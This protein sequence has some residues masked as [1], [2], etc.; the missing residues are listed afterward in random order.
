MIP[1][2][3]KDHPGVKVEVVFTPWGDAYTE[4]ILTSY[5][6]GTGPDLL[7][8]GKAPSTWE[9]YRNAA[10]K[11]TKRDG[12]NLIRMGSSTTLIYSN[13]TALLWQNGGEITTPDKTKATFN[14]PEGV[15][16]LEFWGKTFNSIA[17]PG[18]VL[19]APIP[20][21]AAG[22]VAMVLDGNQYTARD[23]MTYA[24]EHVDDIAVAPPLKRKEQVTNVFCDWWGIGSQSKNQGLAWE[25]LKFFVSTKNLAAYNETMWFFPP[26]KSAMSAAYIK[27]SPILQA[28]IPVIEKYGR[29]QFPIMEFRRL[30][31][32][33]DPE[34]ENYMRGKKTA[35][36]AL[37]DAASAWD[38]VLALYYKK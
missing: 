19:T 10:L 5:A 2:F 7:M 23:V 11:L 33:L 28:F 4:K 3:E 14:G 9:E 24:P 8:G 36:Q 6:A 26:R 31:N 38:K 32:L 15:E 25:F 34:I 37:D 21:L 13:F 27:G 18:T 29:R 17:A 35:K 12:S 22:K 20:L 16:T 30:R 1:E